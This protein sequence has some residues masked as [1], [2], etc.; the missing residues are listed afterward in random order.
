[1]IQCLKVSDPDLRYEQRYDRERACNPEIV[2]AGVVPRPF[3]EHL[4]VLVIDVF[5]HSA[6]LRR[7]LFIFGRG[8]LFHASHLPSP[9][10]EHRRARIK[11]ETVRAGRGLALPG[12][13]TCA[14]VTL[15]VPQTRSAVSAGLPES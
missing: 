14:S 12:T 11:P 15:W 9:S 4:D 10:L 5:G 6:L 2:L 7:V 3:D 13:S 1:M 8:L